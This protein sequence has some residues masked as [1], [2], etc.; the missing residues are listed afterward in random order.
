MTLRHPDPRTVPLVV[1]PR[2]IR[3][4][5]TAPELRPLD[6]RQSLLGVLSLP[7]K[8]HFFRTRSRP[9]SPVREMVSRESA[10]S[11]GSEKTPPSPAHLHELQYLITYGIVNNFYYNLVSYLARTGWLAVAVEDEGYWWDG[12]N[13]VQSFFLSE[14][15]QEIAAVLCCGRFV[16]IATV[17]GLVYMVD[18]QSEQ[19]VSEYQCMDHVQCFEW[20][21]AGYLYCGDS[22]GSVHIL[23]VQDG[24]TAVV[25]VVAAFLQPITGMY[26]F[27][28]FWCGF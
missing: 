9:S 23:R 15:R 2:Q 11:A 26:C 6:F 7:E 18:D 20:D 25:C 16:A 10:S 3:R 4:P 12:R 27:G 24:V 8:V 14:N 21:P 1:P 17:D 28:V 5:E 19:I 13:M 22:G